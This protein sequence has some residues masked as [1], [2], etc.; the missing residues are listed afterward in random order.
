ME[1]NLITAVTRPSQVP[2][3]AELI[4][5]VESYTKRFTEGNEITHPLLELLMLKRVEY[6]VKEATKTVTPWAAQEARNYSD[7]E[8]RC[9]YNSKI[10]FIPAKATYDYAQNQEWVSKKAEIEGY[11]KMA[12]DAAREFLD[13]KKMAENELKTIENNLEIAQAVPV[14]DEGE[15]RISITI[16]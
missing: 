15:D 12:E 9:V 3:K 11:Q 10:S 5:I 2:S 13:L 16:L 14:I 6:F 7:K 8:R 4:D 1:N